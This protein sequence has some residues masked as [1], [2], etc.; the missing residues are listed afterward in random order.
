MSHNSQ[1]IIVKTAINAISIIVN[2]ML[3]VV[4]SS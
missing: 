4:L 2:T 1:G 3:K